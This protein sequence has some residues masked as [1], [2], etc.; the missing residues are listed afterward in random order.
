MHDTELKLFQ[1][2]LSDRIHRTYCN[3]ILSNPKL[4]NTGVPQGSIISPLLF[5]L[6]IND[7]YFLNLNSNVFSY[8]DDTTILHSSNDM[9]DAIHK[10]NLDLGKISQWFRHNWL[11]L[12]YEKT[13]CMVFST[14]QSNVIFPQGRLHME[15][16]SL[17]EILSIKLLGVR[18]S[19]SLSW[20]DQI[21]KVCLSLGFVNSI[22]FRLKMM[23]I[24]SHIYISIIE[25]QKYYFKYKIYLKSFLG[26][27]YK[28]VGKI[29]RYF[30]YKSPSVIPR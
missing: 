27:F 2:F 22:L 12:N 6:F 25:I 10:T 5:I 17:E 15:N 8:A 30:H 18:V 3:G 24:P 29:F 19:K 16:F 1:S 4:C 20:D 14:R 11:E 7:L 13:K 26:I 9:E 28:C 21:D 23:S